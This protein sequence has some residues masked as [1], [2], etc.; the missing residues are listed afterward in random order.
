MWSKKEIL[1]YI[2]NMIKDL[3]ICTV[4]DWCAWTTRVWQFFNNNKYTVCSNDLNIWSESFW[5]T[6]LLNKTENKKTY[7][8]KIDYL[9]SLKGYNGYYTETYWG[10]DNNGLSIQ[11]DWKKRL[12]QIHNTK[13]LDAI[14]DEIEK[15]AESDLEKQTLLTSLILALDKVDNSLWHFSSYLK[16]WSPRSYNEIQLKLP[17]FCEM[18]PENKVLTWDVF[19]IIKTPFD[20]A[21]FDPPYWSNNDKMPSSRVRYWQYYHIR[22]T[23][24]KHDKPQTIWAINKRSDATVDKTYSIFEDYTKR[25]DFF[26]P[27]LAIFNLIEQTNSKYIIL[28]YNT[29]WRAEIKKIIDFLQQNRFRYTLKTIGYKKNVMANMTWTWDWDNLRARENYEILLLIYK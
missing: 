27:E 26:I 22:E 24:I 4:L 6:F 21:Y 11:N 8:D 17:N 19:S 25:G 5:K 18:M 7:Q 28:S 9:N 1:P 13:K 14:R 16:K 23:I 15:I 10:I 20:L 3:K 29:N 12:W 2:R